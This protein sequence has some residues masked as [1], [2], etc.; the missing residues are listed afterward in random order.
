MAAAST[1]GAPEVVTSDVG[2]LAPYGDVP[3]LARSCVDA[4]TR[5]WDATAIKARADAFSYSGFRA[6]LKHFL[7]P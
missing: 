7:A 6:R 4:L 5:G 3:A 2:V 1:G